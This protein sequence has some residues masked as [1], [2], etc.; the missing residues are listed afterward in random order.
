MTDSSLLHIFLLRLCIDV[1][2]A[3]IMTKR[4]TT[5]YSST[6]I[7]EAFKVFQDVSN[8]PK[9]KVHIDT[10]VNYITSYGSEKLSEERARELVLQMEVDHEGYINYEE[11]VDMMMHW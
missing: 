10:I 7:K 4:V 8:S 3:A 6:Q 9:G 2:F 5:K 1:E 11:Y